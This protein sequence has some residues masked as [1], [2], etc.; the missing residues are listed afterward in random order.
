MKPGLNEFMG[1]FMGI[2]MSEAQ[3]GLAANSRMDTQTI[4]VCHNTS[5]YL[6]LH[7]EQVIRALVQRYERV[8]CI[9]PEDGFEQ[10]LADAGAIHEPITIQ[11]HG[12]NPFEELKF[13]ATLYRLYRKHQPD[14]VFNFSIKPCL[15]GG[16]AAR[17]ARV[18]NIACMVTGLG[19]VFLTETR[20]AKTLRGVLT[21]W[22]RLMLRKRDVLF[23]QNPD[24]ATLFMEL[25][26]ARSCRSVVL[27]GTGIDT[28]E[29]KADPP[30]P[31]KGETRFL[32]IGR[33]LKD[34]GLKELS[35][36][37]R[38]LKQ[39]YPDAVFSLLGPTDQNPSAI[40]ETEI[41]AWVDEG[42]IEYLGETRDVRPY[43]RATD[44]FVL[45]SYR[46]GLP[47]SGLEAMS[48]SRPVITT[49]TPGCR[50]LVVDEQNGYLVE[51][52]NAG[53]LAEAME[54]LLEHPTRCATM[55]MASRQRS[56]DFFD[57]D[58]VC[59]Q[60]LSQ[61]TGPAL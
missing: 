6:W 23:F 56:S 18:R 38:Q 2:E 40:S 16:V 14:V 36:A 33:L 13:V 35:L 54:K 51:A 20:F 4:V 57:V 12:M 26:I 3:R 30:S 32:Y 11:Q 45:P 19:Y 37:A 43:I 31:N 48:M 44:V 42:I 8:I 27:P 29:F 53:Q 55:G 46:E 9:T 28:D 1:E 21:M 24:D 41:Q 50:E 7:Y 5:R 22:Y 49:N 34:K 17:L 15:Y 47:R 52:R 25:G 58:V 61:L 39:K 10:F 59:K 60:I